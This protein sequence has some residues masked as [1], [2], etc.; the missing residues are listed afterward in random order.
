MN[1]EGNRRLQETE[2]KIVSGAVGSFLTAFAVHPLE[3]VKVRTQAQRT[4]VR[5]CS[6]DC[7]VILNNGL[8]DC[9]LPKNSLSCMNPTCNNTVDAAPRGAAAR[10]TFGNMRHIFFKEGVGS[11]YAGLGPTLTMG[12]PNTIIYFLTYDELSRKMSQRN[13]D[14]QWTPALA[15]A[16][17]RSIASLTTA[18]L[19]LIR[20]I[21]ASRPKSNGMLSEFQRIVRQEGV[22]G[23][24][25]GLAPS[26]MRD[27]PFSSI[28]WMSIE[29]C[30]A[31]WIEYDGGHRVERVTTMEHTGRALFNG[32]VSGFIAAACTTPLDVIKT[33]QQLQGDVVESPV[34]L[35]EG[36]RTT[37]NTAKRRGNATSLDIGK[38]ILAE[39]GIQGFWRG[40]VA[41]M[42]KVAPACACMIASYEVGQKLY[43]TN[44]S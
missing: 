1:Q 23:L 31:K 39:E 2:A 36:N 16:A 14:N 30:R 3:V 10:G 26:L 32:T 33:N 4:P 41:R 11:L 7:V 34:L 19:E 5:F 22:V 21:Q 15:G 42:T 27:V 12:V 28:Y 44:E 43:M 38:R 29:Y 13:L 17:A 25:R 8:G 35:S 24:Y 37:T 9:S 40:N 20:T 6:P 18:P